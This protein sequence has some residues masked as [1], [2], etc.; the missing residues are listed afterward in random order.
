MMT[1]AR[2]FADRARRWAAHDSAIR[3]LV[4][5]GSVAQ[6]TDNQW[7]DL[8][9]VVVAEPGCRDEVW[10]RR[11]GI[12]RMVLGQEPIFVQEPSWQRPYRYQAWDD[13][14]HELDL[15]IDEG[16]AAV[17]GG[18]AKG[19]EVLLDRADVAEQLTADAAAWTPPEYD[20]ASLDGGTW[21]WFLYLHAKLQH[22]ERFAVRAGLSETLTNRVMPLLGAEWHSAEADLSA[23]DLDRVHAAF[24][25]SIEPGELTRALRDTATVYEWALGRWADRTGNARPRSPLALITHT[26][27]A[28]PDP[29]HLPE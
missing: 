6:G 7:S 3:A 20:A 23:E 5:F 22:G 1:T 13:N 8:D 19:F 9:L 26:R 29:T 14:G 2:L 17:F 11:A 10:H 12:T 4:V 24:P 15:T 16:S 18:I 25:T 27:L 28:E 21:V